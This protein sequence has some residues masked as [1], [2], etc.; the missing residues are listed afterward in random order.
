MVIADAV[1]EGNILLGKDLNI[2]LIA[3]D[4]RKKISKNSW[5]FSVQ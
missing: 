5:C 2:N 3:E 1:F 4:K